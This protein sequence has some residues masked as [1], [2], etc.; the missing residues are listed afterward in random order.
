MVVNGGKAPRAK[1]K[2]WLG[3]YIHIQENGAE[4]FIIEK[5]VGKKRYHLSTRCHS[6]RS[7]LKQLE[8]FEADPQGYT[9]G[10]GETEEALLLDAAL[11]LEYRTQMEAESGSRPH[12][13][14]R[15]NRLKDWM[16]DLTG[17]DLRRMSL[18]DHIIPALVRRKTC[19]PARII[20]IKAL[21]GW[22]RKQRHVLTS[23]E[24]ATVDLPVPQAT[25]EKWRRRKAVDRKRALAAF[26][27]LEGPYRDCMELL[28]ATGWHT[29]ELS[30][31]VRQAESEIVYPLGLRKKGVRAVLVTRHKGGEL[32]RTPLR[33]PEHL[34]AAKRLRARGR[35]PKKLNDA[36]GEAC[37]LAGVEKFTAGVM[38]HSVG[39][40][41]VEDGASPADVS[42]F[43]GHKDPR[44]TKRFYLD[45]AIPTV[46]VPVLRLLKA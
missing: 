18:R 32:T 23:A 5:K 40:W 24:D 46:T 2:R 10:G 9:P 8:R 42:E 25:P 6:E 15:C 29:T 16:V 21:M 14:D 44:T 17:V 31:F 35:M 3:G 41:A 27:K 39:T 1:R 13:N 37:R 20:A 28:V 33:H 30:R 43:L 19:R 7:A 45:V 26:A 38:R 4:L 34:E 36:L 22:L 12:V 11:I